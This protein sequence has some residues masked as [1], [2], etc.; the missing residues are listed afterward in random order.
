MTYCLGWKTKKAVFLLADTSVTLNKSLGKKYS[1]FGELQGSQGNESVV[2]SLLKINAVEKKAAIAFAGDVG[3]ANSVIESLQTFLD[4]GKPYRQA[5]EAAIANN[6][7]LPSSKPISLILAYV[8]TNS[9]KLLYFCSESSELIDIEDVVQIG[10]MGSYYPS[11][12]DQMIRSFIGGT[13]KPENILAA[14]TGVVQ[15]Y[16]IHA[17]LSEMYVGGGFFGLYIDQSGLYWQEDTT[18]VIYHINNDA[19]LIAGFITIG[20]RE[21]VLFIGS[22]LL[23]ETKFISS[24]ISATSMNSWMQT[25]P[26]RI[27]NTLKTYSSD[28]Y[29]FLN[30]KQQMATIVRTYGN[31][32]NEYFKIRPLE[33]NRVEIL[34]H[35]KFF[36]LIRVISA[37]PIE[38]GIPFQLAWLH[39]TNA[40]TSIAQNLQP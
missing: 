16:G 14:I 37:E 5:L 11:F 9:P 12:S 6:S 3:L 29:V 10:S 32:M 31:L 35:D 4:L 28:F 13:S 40:D 18:Y 34:I 33:G 30:T 36:Q 26:P 22:S 25:W 24:H 27:F 19:L 23:N 20:V 7:P 39:A 21:N 8:D 17:V 15:T 2:E 38:D 1:S